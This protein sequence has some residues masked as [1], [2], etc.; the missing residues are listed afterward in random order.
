MGRGSI[1]GGAPW[2]R[3]GRAGV[4]PGPAGGLAASGCRGRPQ[5]R[6]GGAPAAAV[7]SRYGCVGRGCGIS[8]GVIDWD[9]L[10]TRGLRGGWRGWVAE[11]AKSRA[12]GA[13]ARSRLRLQLEAEKQAPLR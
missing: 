12:A 10:S 11:A 1:G 8:H 7:A 6:A 9:S 13:M 4:S 5:A 3:R 2:L